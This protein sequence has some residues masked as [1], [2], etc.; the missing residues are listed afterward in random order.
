LIYTAALVPP[1]FVGYCRYRGFMHFPSDILLGTV[2]GAAVGV[3]VPHLHKITRKMNKNIA[4]IP[5]TGNYSGMSFS[6]RF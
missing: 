6:M 4:I 3:A 5:F 2:V 1:A